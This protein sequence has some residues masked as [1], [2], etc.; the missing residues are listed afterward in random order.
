MKVTP[1]LVL[2]TTFKINEYLR[3]QNQTESYISEAW[4]FQ[5]LQ[6]H[7][8]TY[9]ETGLLLSDEDISDRVSSIAIKRLRANIVTAERFM[10]EQQVVFRP[11]D[12]RFV[13]ISQNEIS[14]FP[15]R[16]QMA[17]REQ[18]YDGELPNRFMD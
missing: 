5:T 16:G 8:S 6:T 2:L 3:Q 12:D 1:Q 7:V 10:N 17:L 4:V 18:R 14:Q 11:F 15:P 13:D 9:E